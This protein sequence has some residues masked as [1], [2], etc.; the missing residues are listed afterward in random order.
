MQS[1]AGGSFV[2]KSLGAG[3]KIVGPI[4]IGFSGSNVISMQGHRLRPWLDVR[5]QLIVPP[6]LCFVF[7]RSGP[8]VTSAITVLNDAI[9]S[10]VLGAGS[11]GGSLSSGVGT[12]TM[13]ISS[14][15]ACA[16]KR[17]VI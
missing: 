15:I 3:A 8:S 17:R 2:F 6:A 5:R 7:V 1:A 13:M 4:S 12:V 14:P 11:F 10:F 9:V 16:G